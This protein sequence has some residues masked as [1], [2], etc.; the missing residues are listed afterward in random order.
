LRRAAK[1]E[2]ILGCR[3]V[4]PTDETVL[5]AAD[6]HIGPMWPRALRTA[7]SGSVAWPVDK[8]LDDMSGNQDAATQSDCRQL[9]SMNEFVGESG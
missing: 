1:G 4:A 6:L 7:A 8:R 2:P 3:M 5:I 9:A